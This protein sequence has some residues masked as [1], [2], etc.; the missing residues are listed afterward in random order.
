MAAASTSA[1]QQQPQWQRQ[2]ADLC[3]QVHS[4]A[5]TVLCVDAVPSD[6]TALQLQRQVAVDVNQPVR[7]VAG[8]RLLEGSATLLECGLRSG[9]VVTAV[10]EPTVLEREIQDLLEKR[11][12]SNLEALRQRVLGVLEQKLQTPGQGDRRNRLRRALLQMVHDLAAG[13]GPGAGASEVGAAVGDGDAAPNGVEIAVLLEEFPALLSKIREAG[14]ASLRRGEAESRTHWEC[15]LREKVRMI[16]KLQESIIGTKCLTRG[17]DGEEDE[18]ELT[19]MDDILG[20]IFLT[21]DTYTDFEQ[22]MRKAMFW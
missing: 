18:D 10:A 1:L 15:R 14:Y 13:T 17:G 11:L 12:P 5:G 19:E 22:K 21:S 8:Q 9:D 4:M 7:L 2:P 6:W 20:E 3:L 16:R